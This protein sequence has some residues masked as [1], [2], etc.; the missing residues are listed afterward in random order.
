MYGLAGLT[1]FMDCWTEKLFLLE[2]DPGVAGKRPNTFFFKIIFWKFIFL[3][4]PLWTDFFYG[5]LD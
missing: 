4:F 2:S 1:F 5:L 3:D